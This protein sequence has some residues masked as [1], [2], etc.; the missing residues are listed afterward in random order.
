MK[1]ILFLMTLSI[2]TGAFAFDRTERLSFSGQASD[3]LRLENEVTETRYRTE[4]YADTCTREV[5]YQDQEC[6]TVT[7]YRR[8]CRTE[9]EPVCQNVTRYRRQCEPSQRVCEP[10]R[11]ECTP[12]RRICENIPGGVDCRI[13]NG[14]RICERRPDRQECR[15]VPGQCHET[16]GY[17]REI[18]GRCMDVPYTERECRDVPRQVCRDVPYYEQ[19]CRTVTR[20]RTESYSCMKTRQVPYQHTVRRDTAEL[21]FN[22]KDIAGQSRMEFEAFL[23]DGGEVIVKGFD[24][25]S[26]PV[27]AV[28]KKIEEDPRTVGVD[29]NR[30][31][32]FDV[33]F[34]DQTRELA[35]IMRDIS[36]AQMLMGRVV[37]ETGRIFNKDTFKIRMNVTDRLGTLVNRDL[38]LREYGIRDMETTSQVAIDLAAL[39]LPRRGRVNVEFRIA[40]DL[41][42][43]VLNDG[44][45][46]FRD[47]TLQGDF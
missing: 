7:R 42:G 21:E 20:Y 4:E 22:F 29:T 38:D 44:L 5:P 19:V 33:T 14:R 46:L 13:E 12:G 40:V 27:V 28:A 8:D 24:R 30:K 10:G 1:L 6:E 15:E 39:N 9:M 37:F 11:R 26:R 17:C 36:N 47:G 25:S 35:P 23:T 41:G 31:I 43:M 3:Y 32:K 2:A 16:P 45:V 34:L 18:P